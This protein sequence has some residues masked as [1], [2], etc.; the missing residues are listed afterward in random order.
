MKITTDT[1]IMK[2]IYLTLVPAFLLLLFSCGA[3]NTENYTSD[4][5]KVNASIFQSK[6]DT[7]NKYI[8]LDVRSPEEFATNHIKGAVNINVNFSEFEDKVKLLDKSNTI[9]VYCKSGGR[10]SKAFSSIQNLGY[11]VYELAGGLLKWQS[12]GFP[13][14]VSK[15][16]SNTGHTLKTYNDAINANSMTLVDFY[17]TWCGPCKMMA[18][19]IESLKVK[20]GDKIAIVKVDTDKSM[21][22]S[23]HFKI[24][25]IPLIKIYKD[26]QEV[27]NKIG[28]HSEEEL[29]AAFS[30][31]L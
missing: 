27:Y 5:G 2:N 8:L 15:D 4:G 1:N 20:Y 6:M 25:A 7:E 14:E 26:G 29:E 31:H 23:K 28:Y 10:S 11:N 22:V 21:E 13:V 24:S 30:S 16:K 3:K 9:L 18:P 12:A 17:A 19:H